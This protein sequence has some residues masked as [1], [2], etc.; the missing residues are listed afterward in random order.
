MSDNRPGFDELAR[1]VA[2]AK[3]KI[4]PAYE[5]R[6]GRKSYTL[7]PDKP[8]LYEIMRDRQAKE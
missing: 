6:E 4:L 3:V 5:V 1:C 8:E 2:K 7:P